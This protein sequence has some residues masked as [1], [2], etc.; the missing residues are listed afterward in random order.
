MNDNKTTVFWAVAL[1]L[2]VGLVAAAGTYVYMDQ[3]TVSQA[4]YDSLQSQVNTLNSQLAAAQA[5]ASDVTLTIDNT[6]YDFSSEVNASYDVPTETWKNRTIT[7]TNDESTSQNIRLDFTVT[8]KDDGLPTD[9][10]NDDFETYVYN[11]GDGSKSWLFN[12]DGSGEYESGWSATIPA[13]TQWTRTLST[14][15]PAV[16]DV[17]EDGQSYDIDVYLVAGGD[18]VDSLDL[19]LIT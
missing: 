14:Y 13:D 5:P 19:T 11:S 6:T 15:M 4:E 1:A 16:D 17:F 12:H 18:V 3:R 10:V 9:L 7:I 2:I 8:G